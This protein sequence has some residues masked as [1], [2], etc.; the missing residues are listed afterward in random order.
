MK[1]AVL[2]DIHSNPKALRTVLDDAKAQGCERFICLG[3]IVGYGYDPNTC[4]DICRQEGIECLMG[5]HDAGLTGRMLLT[6]FSDRA[7][8]GINRQLCEVD[9]EHKSWLHLLPYRKREDFGAWRC[10]F[11]H[12]TFSAPQEFEY[13]KDTVDA[14][15]EMSCMQSKKCDILFV[16]HTHYAEAYGLDADEEMFLI[17]PRREGDRVINMNDYTILIV[18]V[19]SV[20]YP[21]N[22]PYSYYCIFDTEAQMVHY[23][24]LDFDFEDY[25]SQM[26][27]KGAPIPM[28]LQ[29]ELDERRDTH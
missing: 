5:N 24:R 21:R 19:G 8:A 7:R 11:A 28:W 2:S 10:G 12:G 16:G 3:D 22:Q 18:N 25:V 1:I 6:W 15:L 20:G 9:K 26:E 13:I 4:I 29:R 14:R 23:R 17:A 27:S